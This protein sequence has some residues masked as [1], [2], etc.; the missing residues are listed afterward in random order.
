MSTHVNPT[1]HLP[2]FLRVLGPSS[3]TLYKHVLGR[4]RILIYTQP[5]VE[6]AC[7]LCQVAAD[8]CFEDQTAL[9]SVE[10]ATVPR[11]RLTGK[12]KEGINVLG[13]VTLHDIGRL[14]RE[15]ETGRGWV[16]CAFFRELC[17][18]AF[19][20][21]FFSHV[22]TTDAVFLEKPQYYDLV[23]DMTSFSPERASRPG[24]QLSVKEPNGRSRRPSYRLST[25]RF[26]W[27]DVKLVRSQLQSPAD[28]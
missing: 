6:L 8:I 28:L 14:E 25:I 7:M 9:D 3:L 17:T 13:V 18:F 11:P 22:G 26:T 27:S 12:Q 23:I 21:V 1:L 20:T 10:S 4:K 5:P 19:L 15:S 16:A 2:H 24:L